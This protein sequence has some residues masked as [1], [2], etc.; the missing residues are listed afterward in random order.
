MSLLSSAIN[1]YLKENHPEWYAQAHGSDVVEIG[2]C[3]RAG[4]CY[5]YIIID[6]YY[7]MMAVYMQPG[8]NDP[9]IEINYVEA[10]LLPQIT[11]AIN[12]INRWPTC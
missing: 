5:S 10:T 6:M 2:L 1:E 11:A 4:G 9:L 3:T 8:D 7:N 12:E